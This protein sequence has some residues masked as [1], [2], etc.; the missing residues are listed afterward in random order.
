M[1]FLSDVLDAWWKRT[2]E[3]CNAIG[4]VELALLLAASGVLLLVAVF[5]GKEVGAAICTGIL[6]AFV[7]GPFLYRPVSAK[8]AAAITP[9]AEFR[10]QLRVRLW[11]AVEANK[12]VVPPAHVMG[13]L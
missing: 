4:P 3:F 12:L 2:T 11:R 5:V 6:L 7:F 8:A 9:S 1:R 10:E 13:A